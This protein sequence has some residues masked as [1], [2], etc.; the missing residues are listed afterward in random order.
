MNRPTPSVSFSLQVIT[1]PTIVGS[2]TLDVLFL[3][4]VP[5]LT[6][7]WFKKLPTTR[8]LLWPPAGPHQ[9]SVAHCAACRFV[10]GQRG[11]TICGEI[12]IK[13]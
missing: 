2:L 10:V 3:L 9:Y 8:V 1:S 4:S 5:R 13:I 11:G 12:K 7:L 6:G